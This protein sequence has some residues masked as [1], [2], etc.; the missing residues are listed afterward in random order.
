EMTSRIEL[1]AGEEFWNLDINLRDAQTPELDNEAAAERFEDTFRQV[2]DGKA[3]NDGLNRL[4]LIAGLNWRQV[5]LIRCYAKYLLQIG[6]PFSQNYMEDVLV[7]HAGL[8][9]RLVRRFEPQFPPGLRRAERR[10]KPAVV[11]A[12]IERGVARARNID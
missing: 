12:A 3:E 5:A 6:I 7:Q 2:L 4:V 9:Q 1:K 10:A 11:S 8:G